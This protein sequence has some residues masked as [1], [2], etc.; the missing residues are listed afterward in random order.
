MSTIATKE[1]MID[2]LNACTKIVQTVNEK[3]SRNKPVNIIFERIGV[4][5][6]NE[7]FIAKE[8]N[9]NKQL[10]QIDINDDYF[11]TKM[12][13]EQ[14]EF[15]FCGIDGTQIRREFKKYLETKKLKE[16]EERK[17]RKKLEEEAKEA[18]RKQE[19]S[20]TKTFLDNAH[21]TL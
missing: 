9:T 11:V 17:Q 2:I 10:F 3:T 16:E 4:S 18:K 13:I 8:S 1:E 12:Y 20:Q 21:K 6:R 19:I 7:L 5:P 15:L 14:K